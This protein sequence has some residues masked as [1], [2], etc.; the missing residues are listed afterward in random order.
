MGCCTNLLDFY[1]RLCVTDAI[2]WHPRVYWANPPHAPDV[3]KPGMLPAPAHFTESFAAMRM[4]SLSAKRSVARAMWRM[5]RMG[6][7]GRAQWEGRTFSEFLQ[8]TG[9]SADVVTRAT[10]M[11]TKS[12]P[13]P[14]CRSFKKDFLLIAKRL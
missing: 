6:A 12:A 3:M 2:E 5:L 8:E 7:T 1:E 9:Q 14:R 13:L 11:L 4:L 10:W